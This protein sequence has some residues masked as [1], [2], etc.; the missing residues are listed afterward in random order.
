MAELDSLWGEDFEIPKEREKVKK[1]VDK[2]K[3][4]KEAKPDKVKVEK[5]IKSKALSLD[6]KLEAITT[7]VLRVLGHQKENVVV[8]K[9]EEALHDYISDCLRIGRVAV[10]TETNNSLDPITCK[11]MGPCL[12]APGL[13]QAYIPV[14]HVDKDT[15]VRLPWQVSEEV[16]R[17]E[18]QR[19]IDG[20]AY[21][22]MHN[23]KFDYQVIKCT[24]NIDM[25]IHWDTLIAAKLLDEN[26]YSAGLKQQYIAKI[27]PEQEKY[28]IDELFKNVEYA[29][30]DPDIFALY[31][32]T[33]SMMTDKLYEWQRDKFKDPDLARV[34][35]LYNKIELP[36]VQV[37][38]EMELA[39]MAVDQDYAKLLSKTFHEDLAEVDSAI[40]SELETL[41]P[42]IDAWRLSPE[43][44]IHPPKKQGEGYGKSK[45]EQLETPIN[46]ASPTQLAILFYDVLQCPPVSKKSP[47]GTGEDELKAIE[48]IL[49]L[50]LCKLLLRRRELVKLITTYVDVIPELAT[51][52]PDGRVRTHFNQYGA[53]T[54]RL[55]SSDPINFQNVPAGD[56]RIRMLFCS[57]TLNCH[58]E[59]QGDCFEVPEFSEVFVSDSIWKYP[60]E[61]KVGDIIELEDNITVAIVGINKC[62]KT[63][64]LY[65]EELKYI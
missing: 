19:L 62:D 43:A 60:E 20:G 58:I 57:P 53:A 35:D 48:K 54:G 2:I 13:K 29:V 15:R 50:E 37:L 6:A 42:L 11:L 23:G 28:S 24:C 51:R 41:Q 3:K 55:S 52:W 40:D 36:L 27:D 14:N 22:V 46:L 31:A 38:A 25:P 39:G 30:V 61:L 16:I 1:I 64:K 33:D 59:A 8:I 17:A 47:R 56:K 5:Q 26:E 21:I 49:K 4:P 32:A 12:Y 10:D 63:Y 18:L 45:N 65:I 34:L 7:E 44:N 9:S